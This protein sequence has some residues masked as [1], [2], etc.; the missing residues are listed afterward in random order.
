MERLSAPKGKRR[1][2]RMSINMPVDLQVDGESCISPGLVINVSEGGLLVQTFKELPVGAKISIVAL[3][4]KGFLPGKIIAIAE[5][6]WKD[7]YLWEDW[8]GYQYGLKFVQI[9]NEDYL[10]LKKILDN[11]SNLEEMSLVDS[12]HPEET[13]VLKTRS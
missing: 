6:I 13:V 12:S 5:V 4:S 8:E 7:T 1:Y 9:S 2:P 3:L 10:K 11:Q